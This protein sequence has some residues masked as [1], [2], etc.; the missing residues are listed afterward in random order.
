MKSVL[1]KKYGD[2]SVMKLEEVEIPKIQKDE[3][4]VKNSA[5]GV[6]FFD[7]LFRRG[8]F[9][10]SEM[11]AN[12]GM[13]ACGIVE[14]IGD[15][16]MGIKVG[17]RVAYATT[18]VGSY[19]EKKA[20]NQRHIITIPNNIS[21]VE[22]AG[23]LFKGIAAHALLHRVYLAVRAQKIIIHSA[24]GGLG[25]IMT[26]LAKNLNI[27][28]IGTVGDDRKATFAQISGCDHV[29]NYNK[30]DIVAEVMKITNNQGVGIVYDGIGKNSIDKSLKCLKPMGICISHGDAAGTPENIDFNLLTARSLYLSRPIINY[31]KASRPELVLTANEIFAAISK[32]I[33]KPQIKVYNFNEF[34]RAHQALESRASIGSIVLKL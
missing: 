28:V 32:K 34:T 30:S 7:I 6:N 11:P 24:A 21:D 10:L 1:V 27:E 26:S 13:E 4:L 5:I 12:I 33:I 25:S 31:Y 8:Q 2:P 16:V 3:V 20:V 9:I 29:I 18:G 22:V 14:K 19:C 15:D 23:T 17:D